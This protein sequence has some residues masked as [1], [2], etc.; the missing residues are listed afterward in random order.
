[1]T[2]TSLDSCNDMPQAGHTV[3]LGRVCVYSDDAGTRIDI[4]SRRP[5]PVVVF[6]G[7][8]LAAWTFAGV[9]SFSAFLGSLGGPAAFTLF[10]GVWCVVWAGGWV[11]TAAAF[12]WMLAGR[13]VVL[14]HDGILTKRVILPWVGVSRH[15][16]ADLIRNLRRNMTTG[17]LE[18]PQEDGAGIPLGRYGALAFDHDGE[19]VYLG[20]ALGPA[21]AGVLMET[22]ETW[23][24][25]QGEPA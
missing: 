12:L 23:L 6:L 11:A 2:A 9:V 14:L 15:Y 3:Q 21:A 1:M 17:D 8:W 16:H 19:T 22:I 13:E 7:V 20:A 25:Q 18:T 24:K 4:P 5:G 10:I